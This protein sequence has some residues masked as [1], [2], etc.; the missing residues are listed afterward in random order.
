MLKQSLQCQPP[1]SNFY[2][3]CGC[4]F[5]LDAQEKCVSSKQHKPLACHST[6]DVTQ[7]ERGAIHLSCICDC[8]LIT[9]E[10]TPPACLSTSH[11]LT[12]RFPSLVESL[13][14]AHSPTCRDEDCSAVRLTDSH[15]RGWDMDS[16]SF[17]WFG[18]E[19]TGGENAF[20]LTGDSP[21]KKNKKKNKKKESRFVERE[22]MKTEWG[23]DVSYQH[24]YHPS[25]ACSNSPAVQLEST[26]QL[27]YLIANS[28]VHVFFY[29]FCF[30]QFSPNRYAN[31]KLISRGNA[32]I[33]N[34]TS[35]VGV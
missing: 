13:F 18:Q 25:L 35:P 26:Q 10:K 30:H 20:S 33:S 16:L 31:V 32:H 17:W 2:S 19:Q 8:V 24:Q 21:N 15:W 23:M 27:L 29:F 28:S 4:F 9:S 1:S 14:I 3:L 12:D 5:P 11:M 6:T 7:P 22:A 34:D